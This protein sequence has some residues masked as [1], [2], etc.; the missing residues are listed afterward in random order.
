MVKVGIRA[1]IGGE[2][3]HGFYSEYVTRDMPTELAQFIVAYETLYEQRQIP[4]SKLRFWRLLRRETGWPN[5]PK[6]RFH[7]GKRWIVINVQ[8]ETEPQSKAPDNR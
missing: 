1:L 3:M 2:K 5:L 8:G 7:G 6:P 4:V